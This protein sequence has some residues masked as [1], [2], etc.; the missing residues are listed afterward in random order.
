MMGRL[1][2][3]RIGGL[4]R[5]DALSCEL[6]KLLC[7]YALFRLIEIATSE[8]LGVFAEADGRIV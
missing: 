7:A 2:M 6:P 1:K 4:A 5:L 8:T 3:D